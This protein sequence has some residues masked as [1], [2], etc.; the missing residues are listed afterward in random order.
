MCKDMCK[1]CYNCKKH[2]AGSER[3]EVMIE[4]MVI[5]IITMFILIWLLGLGFLY[6]QRYIAVVATNDAAVKIAATY[7]NSTSDIVMGYTTTEDMSN[8]DLYRGFTSGNLLENNE[9]RTEAY[10]RYRLDKMNFANTIKDVDVTLELIHDSPVRKHIKVTADCEF[11]TPFGAG[12]EIIGMEGTR[13]Y[14]FTACADCT[15]VADYI[16]TVTFGN[17]LGS[18]DLISA[19]DFIDSIIGLLNSLVDVFNR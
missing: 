8:R 13:K 12:M 1:T 10:I 19:G 14:T 18:G 7:N 15:D 3:G 17:A 11:N 5:V 2:R 9:N 6:Y 4:S 16:S